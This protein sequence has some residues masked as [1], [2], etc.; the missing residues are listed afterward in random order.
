LLTGLSADLITTQRYYYIFLLLL[1]AGAMAMGRSFARQSSIEY[2]TLFLCS[3][4][5]V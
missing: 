1:W 5:P 3:V 4:I 2:R